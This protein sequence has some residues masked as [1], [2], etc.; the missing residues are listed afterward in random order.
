MG[1]RLSLRSKPNLCLSSFSISVS[2]AATQQP[3][4]PCVQVGLAQIELA[5]LIVIN[6]PSLFQTLL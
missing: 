5:D 6:S 4:D 2:A 3:C 1:G